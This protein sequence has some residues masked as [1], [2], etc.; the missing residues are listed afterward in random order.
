M[1]CYI[2]A[3]GLGRYKVLNYFTDINQ[4]CWGYKH[5]LQSIKLNWDVHKFNIFKVVITN[6][7]FTFVHKQGCWLYIFKTC[8][9][10]IIVPP[11]TSFPS[12]PIDPIFS[13]IFVLGRHFDLSLWTWPWNLMGSYL[14]RKPICEKFGPNPCISFWD[15]L[16]TQTDRTCRWKQ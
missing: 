2:L 14:G 13:Y 3:W 6:F 12:F 8:C 9:A 1:L 4:N 16:L 15:I 11:A 5:V 7:H 10:L